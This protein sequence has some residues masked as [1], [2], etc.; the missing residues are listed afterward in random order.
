MSMIGA[1][2]ERNQEADRIVK[3]EFMGKQVSRWRKVRDC[4]FKGVKKLSEPE[5]I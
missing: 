5:V 1:D 4:R 2:I 3:L